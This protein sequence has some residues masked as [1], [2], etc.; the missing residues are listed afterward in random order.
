MKPRDIVLVAVGSIVAAACIRLGI[1]QLDRL[2]DRRA[3]NDALRARAG[4]A[5][6]D[7]AMVP[8]DTGE[9]H[10]RRVR[11][12]GTY[13]FD[14]EV[15]L[16]SRSRRGSPGV[17]IITPVR[18]PGRDT[19]V[20]VNRGWIYAPDGMSADLTH[21]REPEPVNAESYVQNFQSRDGPVKSTS[22]PR[23]YRWM[24]RTTISQDFPYPIAPFYL[25]LIGESENPPAEIP[26]RV[27]V[28]ALD[29]GPH[30]SYAFQ[31]FSFATISII[32]MALYLRRK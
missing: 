5:P 20:L 18:L 32:G 10:Y 23:A 24:D 7:F 22:V 8:A 27:P 13:D 2:S 4:T 28:P 15:V 6:V 16:T 21:W 29:E 11:I 19:A 14:N 17:N 31:W 30:R 25:V 1:W 12:V 26:P 3:L 9:A